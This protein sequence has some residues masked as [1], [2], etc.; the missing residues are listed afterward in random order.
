MLEPA[1]WTALD[2]VFGET[3]AEFELFNDKDADEGVVVDIVP[4][5]VVELEAGMGTGV[6]VGSES[7]KSTTASD[8]DEAG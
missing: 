2:G 5:V 3:V 1:D 8:G 4:D 7:V 6:S